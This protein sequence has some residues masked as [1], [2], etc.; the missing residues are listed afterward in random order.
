MNILERRLVDKDMNG[1]GHPGNYSKKAVLPN[2]FVK[3]KLATLKEIKFI[4]QCK[5]CLYFLLL[6][7]LVSRVAISS[8]P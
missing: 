1:M 5:K 3:Y 7:S 8:V 4:E 6:Y 2:I